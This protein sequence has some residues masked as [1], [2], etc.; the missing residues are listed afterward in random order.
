VGVFSE[1]LKKNKEMN[2]A[3]RDTLVIESESDTFSMTADLDSTNVSISEIDRKKAKEDSLDKQDADTVEFRMDVF[4]EK[5]KKN[6]MDMM[7]VEKLQNSAIGSFVAALF[8]L[9]GAFFMFRLRKTGFY[10]YIIG[11]AIGI[12]VPFYIYAGN[13]LAIGMSAFSSFFGLIFIALYA[14]NLKSMR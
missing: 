3:G 14:L 4:G 10:L 8:T 7:S 2:R 13:L 5:I 11:I 1:S 9:A 6:V 12:A